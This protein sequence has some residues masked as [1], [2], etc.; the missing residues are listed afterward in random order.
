[1]GRVSKFHTTYGPRR[2]EIIYE[3]ANPYSPWGPSGVPFYP[4]DQSTPK[5]SNLVTCKLE[6]IRNFLIVK[7]IY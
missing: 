7:F 6:N 1:M 3:R 2:G 5:N 4:R